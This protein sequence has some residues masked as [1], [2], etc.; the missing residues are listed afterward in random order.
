MTRRTQSCGVLG[1]SPYQTV[2]RGD[3]GFLTLGIARDDVP[4][5]RGEQTII[6]KDD[7]EG[8]ESSPLPRYAS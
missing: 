5:L 2:A 6:Q 1:F 8:E 7:D 4:A 3:C